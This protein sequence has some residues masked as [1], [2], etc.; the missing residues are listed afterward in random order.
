M[1]F[2]CSFFIWWKMGGSGEKFRRNATRHGGLSVQ[3]KTAHSQWNSCRK[4]LKE[5]SAF[6]VVLIVNCLFWKSRV[7]KSKRRSFCFL[8]LW[9]LYLLFVCQA[10]VMQCSVKYFVVKSKMKECVIEIYASD[11]FTWMIYC[12]IRKERFSIMCS[13]E[14]LYCNRAMVNLR[15]AY[16]QKA[17]R[18]FRGPKWNSWTTFL[19]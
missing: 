10:D 19:V 17:S 12:T 7:C 8:N 1:Y 6:C 11:S 2:R 14:K 18:F 4:L 13:R 3:Y 5:Y 9:N 15:L 16:M